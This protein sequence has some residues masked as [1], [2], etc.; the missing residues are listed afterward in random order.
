[1]NFARLAESR[2]EQAI[3]AGELKNLPGEG[4]PL[5][6]DDTGGD[7]IEKAGF[8]MMAKAGALPPEILLKKEIAAGWQRLREAED[9]AI[10]LEIM[11]SLA[12]LQMRLAMMLEGRR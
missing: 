7:P 6:K 1:M 5:P 11:R 12:N 4:I 3:E 9:E 8:K 10:K 2:I